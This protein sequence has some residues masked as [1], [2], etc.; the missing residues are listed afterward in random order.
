LDNLKRWATF[1]GTALWDDFNTLRMSWRDSAET[2]HQEENASTS[3]PCRIR[4]IMKERE[5]KWSSQDLVQVYMWF[6]IGASFV[7][8]K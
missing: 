8:F 1:L 2:C 3:P 7:I 4:S 6:A 5:K